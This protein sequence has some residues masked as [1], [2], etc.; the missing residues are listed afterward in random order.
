MK[1]QSKLIKLLTLIGT[2][3]LI[4]TKYGKNY[5]KIKSGGNNENFL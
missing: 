3:S 5:V 2:K 4:G 1:I